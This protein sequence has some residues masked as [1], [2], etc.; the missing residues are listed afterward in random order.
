MHNAAL[1]AHDANLD[2]GACLPGFEAELSGE[3]NMGAH[4][5]EVVRWTKL[6]KVVGKLYVMGGVHTCGGAVEEVADG[7]GDAVLHGG[8]GGARVQHTGA[9]VAELPGFMVAQAL[10]AHSLA[11]LYAQ[12]DAMTCS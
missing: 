5:P 12:H 9:K 4:R 10:Q 6:Q 3:R 7:D 1:K 2:A 11:H 8:H